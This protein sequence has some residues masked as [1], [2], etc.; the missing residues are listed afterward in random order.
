M[1]YRVMKEALRESF[2]ECL[3]E[4]L[5]EKDNSEALDDLLQRADVVM[6][7]FNYNS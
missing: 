7:K 5:E 2:R 3:E 1:N 4:E 6:E